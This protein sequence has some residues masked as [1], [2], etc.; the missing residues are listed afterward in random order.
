MNLEQQ[1]VVVT[2]GAS[3]MGRACAEYF[4]ARGA[5][6]MVWDVHADADDAH[7]IACDVRS[8]EAVQAALAETIGGLGLPR[9]WGGGGG[10]GGG[11]GV[12]GASR[13]LCHWMHSN[14]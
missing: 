6:V 12:G 13:V 4:R 5:Q 14:R 7:A 9:G 8:D 3:G 2:G 1:R 10:G 11:P